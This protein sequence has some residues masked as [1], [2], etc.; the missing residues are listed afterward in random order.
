MEVECNKLDITLVMQGSTDSGPSYDKYTATLHQ[1]TELKDK[2]HTLKN[3]VQLL[4]QLLT[5]ILTTG[6]VSSVTNPLYQ[7]LVAEIQKVKG[8]IQHMV[9]LIKTHG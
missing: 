5:H 1:Q 8:K 6:G 4:E 9:S 7:Q 2:Q 3:G